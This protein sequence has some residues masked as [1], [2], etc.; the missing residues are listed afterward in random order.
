MNK[1]LIEHKIKTL[2]ELSKSFDFEDFNFRQW[3][4]NYRD[5]WLGDAWIAS[6]IITAVNATEAINKFRKELIPIVDCIAFVSQ[7]YT[8]VEFEPFIIIKQNNNL[9]K[10]F[11]LNFTYESKGVPLH[12]DEEEKNALQVLNNFGEKHAFRY[13]RE[14]TNSSTFYTRLAM[15][16]AALESI[17]GQKTING[18]KFTNKEFINKEIIGDANLFKKI[19]AYGE[20]IRPQLF[21]GCEI[22]LGAGDPDYIKEIYERIVGFFNDK[23]NIKINFSVVNPQRVPFGNYRGGKAWLEPK[24]KEKDI[25]LKDVVEIFGKAFGGDYTDRDKSVFNENF[26]SVKMPQNY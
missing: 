6:K 16:V 5:G 24:D 20:G 13:L 14:S 18:K 9:K 2:S 19:F 26:L 15:L 8:T 11:F 1:Y 7:C 23:F 3:D 21:H 4:F 22:N 25:N 17:A 12:F 10:V